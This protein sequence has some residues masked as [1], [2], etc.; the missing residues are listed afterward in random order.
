LVDVYIEGV[1]LQDLWMR[2]QYLE[3]IRQPPQVF[4]FGL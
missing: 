1:L 3:L 4:F 2:S